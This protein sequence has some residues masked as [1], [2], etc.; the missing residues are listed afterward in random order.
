MVGSSGGV[1]DH[2]PPWHPYVRLFHALTGFLFL[3][4]ETFV[5]YLCGLACSSSETGRPG[6]AQ[7]EKSYRYYSGFDLFSCDS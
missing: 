6:T 1:S 7:P 2:L 3:T 4:Q 5:K